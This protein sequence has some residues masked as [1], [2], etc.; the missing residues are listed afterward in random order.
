MYN[1]S[2]V[3]IMIIFDSAALDCKNGIKTFHFIPFACSLQ[4][5]NGYICNNLL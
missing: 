5:D 3:C 1:W 4:L 2:V